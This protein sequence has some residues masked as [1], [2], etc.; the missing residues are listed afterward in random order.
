MILIEGH[1]VNRQS[2]SR[3]LVTPYSAGFSD[4]EVRV[5]KSYTLSQSFKKAITSRQGTI[6]SENLSG[7]PE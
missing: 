3:N 2:G 6:E 5:R 4:T 7:T 1:Q